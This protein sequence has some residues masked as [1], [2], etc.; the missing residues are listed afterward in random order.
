M[1]KD[2]KRFDWNNFYCQQNRNIIEALLDQPCCTIQQLISIFFPISSLAENTHFFTNLD[3]QLSDTAQKIVQY[4]TEKFQDWENSKPGALENFVLHNPKSKDNWQNNLNTL[5]LKVRPILKILVND[6]LLPD[7]IYRLP[8]SQEVDNTNT[9]NLYDRFKKE[10]L[11]INEIIR[12]P[13]NYEDSEPQTLTFDELKKRLENKGFHPSESLIWKAIDEKMIGAYFRVNHNKVIFGQKRFDETNRENN[14]GNPYYLKRYRGLER[15]LARES[16]YNFSAEKI[17]ISGFVSAGN[18]KTI[19]AFHIFNPLERTDLEIK[20]NIMVTLDSNFRGDQENP[21]IEKKDLLFIENEIINLES[22]LI[23]TDKKSRKKIELKNI[24]L[25]EKEN[26]PQEPSK[27]KNAISSEKGSKKS[28]ARKARIKPLSRKAIK[29]NYTR[30]EATQWDT[31]FK[32]EKNNGFLKFRTT[33]SHNKKK[34]Y[35]DKKLI[36]E[37]LIAEGHYTKPELNSLS[38]PHKNQSKSRSESYLM[39]K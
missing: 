21:Y 38:T 25:S 13:E 11:T 31:Y 20:L 14:F 24:F 4:F 5:S 15:L 17:K 8:Q 37:W 7:E 19:T 2:S 3:E 1:K 23:Q 33:S 16:N 18:R 22:G 10:N 35:Y 32:N 39:H 34:I 30:L 6:K 26:P 9:D 27:S 29:K 36:E 12:Q 28:P